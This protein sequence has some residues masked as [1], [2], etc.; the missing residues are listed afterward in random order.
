MVKNL[1]EKTFPNVL[2]YF[3]KQASTNGASEGWIFG[4]VMMVVAAVTYLTSDVSR[5]ISNLLRPAQ[6]QSIYMLFFCP[7][8]SFPPHTHSWRMQTFTFTLHWRTHSS[9]CPTF[10]ITFPLWRNCGPVWRLCPTLPSG[11][12]R[13][14]NLSFNNW[15]SNWTN[16]LVVTGS[17]PETNLET[18]LA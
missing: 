3:E 17:K 1:Q 5:H 15:T 2:G 7:F 14:Q 9:R 8:S 16:E 6:C 18:V 4:K 13:D 12:R 10:W 11:W